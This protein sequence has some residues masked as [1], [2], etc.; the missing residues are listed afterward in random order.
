MDRFPHLASRLF[1]VPLAVLPDKAEVAM[2]ALADRLG[3]AHLF[4]ADGGSVVLAG[5]DALQ[6]ISG[7]G[8]PAA[9]R[10]YSVVSGVALIEVQGLLVQKLGTLQPYCGM[11][12]YDGIRSNF[13][14]AMADPEVK[15]IAFDIDSGGGEVAGCF[16]LTDTIYAARGDKPICAILSETAY[17]AAYALAS[18]CDY[19]TVPR[20]G[21]C[22]SV[23]VITMMVDMSR[24]L[25]AGGVAVHFI[26]YGAQKA[27]A[28]RAQ[29]T[30]VSKE[31]LSRVQASVDRAGELFVETVARNRGM[32]ASAVRATEAACFDGELGVAAGLADAVASPDE[33]FRALLADLGSA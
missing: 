4:R 12:G 10:G 30:G 18:A 3:I 11:T 29:A 7:D 16:D 32:K 14:T 28:S 27:E 21:G 15:A 31:M 33:A 8:M 23:G 25:A 17:S 22:G 19:I 5:S 1:N 24:A 9:Q 2:A 26:H 13:L 6:A 20:T